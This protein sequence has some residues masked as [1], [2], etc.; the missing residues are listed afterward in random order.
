[1]TD[2]VRTNHLKG[3]MNIKFLRLVSVWLLLSASNI[4][5]AAVP[6][7]YVDERG[8]FIEA[9]TAFG[10]GQD[11]AFKQL[12]AKLGDEY[13]IAYY[14][15]YLALQKQFSNQSPKRSH[16]AALKQ[17]E[18][19]NED[20]S[21][22]R[23]LTR[24]LQRRAAASQN[25]SLFGELSESSY[26]ADMPCS[27]LQ[28]QADTGKLK[29]LNK[30]AL[31]L[32]VKPVKHSVNCTALLDK[33]ESRNAP[34]IK[35]I[36]QRI[37]ESMDATKPKYAESV[38][39]YLSRTDRKPVKAWLNARDEPEAYLKSGAIDK[40]TSFNRR[41]FVDLVLKWS[42]EDPVAA[43]NHWLAS[44]EKYGFYSDRYYDTHR[45]LA[46]RGAYRRLPEAY[47]WLNT[48]PGRD[49]DL[50]LKEWRIR[51]A[52][53]AQ[54]WVNVLRS[55]KRLPK[56]EQEE[57]HWAYWEAR[58]LEESGHTP[59]A[60][61]IFKTLS[62]LPTYHGFLAAD[63]LGSEY[64]IADIPIEPDADII[65]KLEKSPSLIR[66]REYYLVDIPWEGRREWNALFKEASPDK[67][68]A[69]AVLAE[70][71]ELYD[72]ALFAAGKAEKKK[73]L[74]TRFPVV[75]Q[76][77]VESAAAAN[78]IPPA[79][80]YGVMRRE[81]GYIRDVKSSAGA[82][83][84]MQL[85]PNTAKYVAKLQGESNWKGDLTDAETNIGFGTFYLRH[86]MDKFDDHQILATASYNA[87]PHRVTYWLPP[88]DMPAD[89]WIDAIPYSETRRYVRAVMAYTAI[90]EWHLTD[91]AER[92]STKLLTVPAA[93]NA[94][95]S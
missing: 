78:R 94:S 53:F 71:W 19:D 95:D 88:E 55:L 92:L 69:L 48:V 21:L 17:F 29:T 57:D 24:Q 32:W 43:M 46:M 77:E 66:A 86:V 64:N 70:R 50:E 82:V 14:L 80:V 44:H 75:F 4:A 42:K 63:K 52:L 9:Y 2:T 25:W 81:S 73:A 16:L 93:Q 37:Y 40:D 23:K 65:A 83:G 91:K 89:V 54:D 22:A 3:A 51:A 60:N 72:R 35:A 30:A 41:A 6:D 33:L 76:P 10:K 68:A 5:A 31:E 84:L 1:M 36:W 34:P 13:P 39:H 18:S 45:L 90:Y 15:D 58:A 47:E 7:A 8:R 59:L 11:K 87:G 12:R 62:E 38:L 28:A 74:T 67:F 56:E 79:W 85:M 61:E 20:T 27:K 26:A 49:D